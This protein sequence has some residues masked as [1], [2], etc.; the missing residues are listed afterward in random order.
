[1]INKLIAFLLLNRVAVSIGIKHED[2]SSD[3]DAYSLYDSMKLSNLQAHT[4]F[5]NADK[6]KG[7][8]SKPDSLSYVGANDGRKYINRM[9]KSFKSSQAT[10]IST[11]DTKDERPANEGIAELLL[12]SGLKIGLAQAKMMTALT[13]YKKDVRKN[14]IKELVKR[15][16]YDPTTNTYKEFDTEEIQQE[17]SDGSSSESSVYTSS[18]SNSDSNGDSDDESQQ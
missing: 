9:L 3:V 16:V 12:E 17:F 7:K 11:S 5:I 14:M 8:G 10:D 18:D 1:M 6:K 13:D 2:K 4:S 15:G